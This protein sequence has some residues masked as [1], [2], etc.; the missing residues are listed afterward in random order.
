ML[1]CILSFH[2]NITSMREYFF[3]QCPRTFAK[4]DLLNAAK[5]S[6]PTVTLND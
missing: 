2:K 1:K 4:S 3:Q 5:L 6:K